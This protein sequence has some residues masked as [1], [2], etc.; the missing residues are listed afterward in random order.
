MAVA[1][2]QLGSPLQPLVPTVVFSVQGEECM[3]VTSPSSRL[4]AWKRA[5]SFS[6][7]DQMTGGRG[8]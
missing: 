7:S 3:S 5:D 2:A 8:G 4:V 1:Q 6:A